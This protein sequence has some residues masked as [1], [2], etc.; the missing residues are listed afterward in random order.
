ML[1][2]ARKN[3]TNPLQQIQVYDLGLDPQ[4]FWIPRL[5]LVSN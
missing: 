1:E 4:L 2:N 5:V 3:M